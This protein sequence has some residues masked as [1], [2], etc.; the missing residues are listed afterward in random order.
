MPKTPD[1]NSRLVILNKYP[2][3]YVPRYR[4]I[5]VSEPMTKYEALELGQKAAEKHPIG[6]AGLGF[7]ESVTA[8]ATVE[9]DCDTCTTRR[10]P[11]SIEMLKFLFNLD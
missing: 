9:F 3:H 7:I 6:V 1:Q 8:P 10:Q 2:K 5:L 4:D 11:Q